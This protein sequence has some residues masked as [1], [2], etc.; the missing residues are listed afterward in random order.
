[1][2][3]YEIGTDTAARTGKA[4]LGPRLIINQPLHLSDQYRAW[5]A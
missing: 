1:M 5:Q 4:E 2:G 3:A